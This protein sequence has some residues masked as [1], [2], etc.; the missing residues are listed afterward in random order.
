MRGWMLIWRKP[1]YRSWNSISGS[2]IC[3]GVPHRKEPALTS[4]SIVGRLANSSYKVSEISPR[5]RLERITRVSILHRHHK[6]DSSRRGCYLSNQA[7]TYKLHP[8]GHL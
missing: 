7:L 4:S 8:F 5:P 3:S 2:M 1:G 6:P